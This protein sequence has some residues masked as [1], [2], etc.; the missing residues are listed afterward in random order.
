MQFRTCKP[1]Q[2]HRPV[3]IKA[4]KDSFIET[5]ALERAVLSKMSTG[6]NWRAHI[7]WLLLGW[8]KTVSHWLGRSRRLRPGAFLFLL[9]GDKVAG[10]VWCPSLP[11]GSE[12]C[13][14]WWA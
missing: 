11:V 9:P 8:V 14:A 6:V 3:W 4:E 13:E 1:Q 7:L 5:E 2:N 10:T 12:I